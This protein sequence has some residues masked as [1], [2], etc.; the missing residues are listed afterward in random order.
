MY[1]IWFVF[2]YETGATESYTYSH[3]LSLHDALPIYTPIV[4][5]REGT[6]NSSAVVGRSARARRSTP[7]SV[8]LRSTVATA[9]VTSAIEHMISPTQVTTVPPTSNAAQWTIG[10]MVFGLVPKAMNDADSVIRRA[11]IATAER[12]GMSA[13]GIPDRKSQRLNSSP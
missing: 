12:R 9:A 4:S 6:P 1:I 13:S 7:T 8:F 5:I 10:V 11:A 2:L 3:T